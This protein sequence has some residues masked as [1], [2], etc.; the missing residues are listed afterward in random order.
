M[1]PRLRPVVAFRRRRAVGLAFATKWSGL[2]YIAFFG[3]MSLAFDVSARRAYRVPRPWLGVLRR[4]LGPVLRIR[5]D[6]ASGLPG[7]VRTV[8]R[9]R[10]RDQPLRGR[11]VDRPR[12]WYQPPDAIRSLWHYTYKAYFTIPG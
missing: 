11:P 12:Q 9:I 4:D 7:V 5:A 2:Y 6:P 8:V 10:D 1:G 3:V